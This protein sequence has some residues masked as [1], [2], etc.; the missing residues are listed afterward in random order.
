VEHTS[1]EC[2]Q[3]ADRFAARSLEGGISIRRATLLM[4][5]ADSWTRLAGQID[6][7]ESLEAGEKL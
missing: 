5:V 1:L 2:R 4:A 7:L 3:Q 6:R